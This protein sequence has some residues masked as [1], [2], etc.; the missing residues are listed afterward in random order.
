M[1]NNNNNDVKNLDLLKLIQ[2]KIEKLRDEVNDLTNLVDES[3]EENYFLVFDTLTTELES[4]LCNAI[5]TVSNLI[6]EI[7]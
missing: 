5:D 7:E 3:D 4:D 2:S 6:D 1:K